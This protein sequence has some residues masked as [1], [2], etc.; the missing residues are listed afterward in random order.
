MKILYAVQATGNG[1]I[2]R[3]YQLIP[4]LEKWGEV[5][6]FLSGSNS[7]M[8]CPL[9][10]KY[11]SAGLSL[12]Y[13]NCG[14]LDYS[15]MFTQNSL[16]KSIRE[17]KSLPVHL[18]DKVINDFDFITA[19]ACSYRKKKCIH[20]GHQAS[21]MSK[22]VPRPSKISTLGEWVLKNYAPSSLF[23]GLH[24]ERYDDFIFPPVIKKEILQSTPTNQ[25]HITVYLPSFHPYCLEKIFLSIKEIEF[26][27]FLPE[28][29][30]PYKNKNITYYPVDN[31]LFTKSLIESQG[32]IT[33]GGFETPA[34]VMFLKKKLMSIP[35]RNHYEQICNAAALRLM[36]VTV[37]DEINA[38]NFH[39]N[40]MDWINGPTPVF[41]QQVNNVDETIERVLDMDSLNY[42]LH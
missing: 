28:I 31:H 17:S 29:D 33:G 24:F 32:V 34:E 12:F 36:G 15:R 6:V 35:I 2:S 14:H 41:D 21:F 1:H 30:K 9:P 10:V 20:F 3:A 4:I 23:A 22:K 37:L 5:D 18:Y 40:I 8:K 38:L 26:Q 25:E 7:S 27:W 42:S 13:K 11:R 16:I 19:R 39:Q